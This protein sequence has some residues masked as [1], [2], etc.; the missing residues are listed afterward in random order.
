M[1][2]VTV[3]ASSLTSDVA[4]LIVATLDGLRAGYTVTVQGVGAPYDGTQVLTATNTDTVDDATVYTVS[5]DLVHANIAAA[6]VDGRITPACTWVDS[7]D[8]EGFL[9]VAPASLSDAAYLQSCVD[10]G[11]DWAYR[12]R[13][14][15]GYDDWA[16]LVPSA[17]VRL[18]TIM[19]A[20]ALY[21][22]RG[23]VDTFASFADMAPL[24][25]IGSNMQVLR[26][27]GLNKPVIA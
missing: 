15:A 13:Q 9:G 20:A 14:S 16:D 24:A 26:L 22:E 5:Y 6:D 12:R 23:S 1:D 21:R 8:V 2:F 4:E 7:T 19:Y 3:S 18:G 27:L 17:D 25:P 11:N 10:A